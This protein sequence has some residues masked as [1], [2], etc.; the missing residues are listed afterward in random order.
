[1]HIL[2]CKHTADHLRAAVSFRAFK[3]N[4]GLISTTQC[5][6]IIAVILDTNNTVNYEHCTYYCLPVG[7]GWSVVRAAAFS[8]GRMW[9][10]NKAIIFVVVNSRGLNWVHSF[11]LV[12]IWYITWLWGWWLKIV[13]LSLDAF[14]DLKT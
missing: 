6:I 9:Y 14:P 11:Q 1:M 12:N 5:V 10:K 4:D 13:C 7:L 2:L 8:S 3:K